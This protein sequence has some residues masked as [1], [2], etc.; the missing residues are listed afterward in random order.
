M[1]R[2]ATATVSSPSRRVSSPAACTPWSPQSANDAS[3]SLGVHRRRR[4]GHRRRL[5]PA[6]E[7]AR[8]E[9]ALLEGGA[10]R[11]AGAA[12]PRGAGPL[13]R[14]QGR[15]QARQRAPALPR[16]E[17]AGRHAGARARGRAP[18]RADRAGRRAGPRAD[19]AHGARGCLCKAHPGRRY[20]AG[21]ATLHR[22]LARR[23]TRVKP[24]LVLALFLVLAAPAAAKPVDVT[25]MT[26]NL[27]LG[28]DLIPIATPDPGDPFQQAVPKPFE[29]A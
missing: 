12:L 23:L 28:T 2:A 22:L 5:H 8:P 25:V 26:P 1:P 14:R 13:P 4:T 19:A 29:A 20:S 6:G 18:A 11:R 10:G 27:F 7:L 3:P 24:T 16:R 9:P 17:A 21:A 15:R